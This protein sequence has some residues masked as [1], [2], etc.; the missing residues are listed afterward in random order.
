MSWKELQNSA[1]SFLKDATTIGA[2]APSTKQESAGPIILQYPA[3]RD[4]AV[5][6][7]EDS[8]SRLY[9][10]GLVFKAYNY[11]SRTTPDLTAQRTEEQKTRKRGGRSEARLQAHFESTRRAG[12]VELRAADHRRRCSRAPGWR[13]P[14]PRTPGRG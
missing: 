13:R 12:C 1:T 11:D 14:P 10:N 5:D 8:V 3:E 6:G 9:R 4:T 7:N 2:G